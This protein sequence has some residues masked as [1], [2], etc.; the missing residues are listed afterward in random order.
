MPV[1]VKR[2]RARTDLVEIWNYIADDSEAQADTFLDTIDRKLALLADQPNIGRVRRELGDEIRSFPLG[3]YTIFYVAIPSGIEVVRVLH[4]A[5]DLDA[6]FQ[7]D[8]N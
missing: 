6:I 5:R 7:S 2:P 1:I 3:R 4:G 8:G